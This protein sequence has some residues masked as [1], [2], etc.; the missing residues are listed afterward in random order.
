MSFGRNKRG[1]EDFVLLKNADR[2]RGVQEP[3]Q[4]S[5]RSWWQRYEREYLPG[6]TEKTQFTYRKM[7]ER[8][9]V[10][11]LGSKPIG[12]IKRS[13]VREWIEWAKREAGPGTRHRHGIADRD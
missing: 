5:F 2:I 3:A 13:H 8:L 7:A 10:K 1:A 4:E 12:S 9:L 6:L 11:Y